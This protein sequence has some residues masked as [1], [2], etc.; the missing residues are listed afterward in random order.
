VVLVAVGLVLPEPEPAFVPQFGWVRDPA[1]VEAVRSSLAAPQFTST[2]AYRAESAGPEDV[3]LWDACRSATGAL[4]PPRNQG[5]IG[6]CVG[7]GTAAALE[8]LACVQVADGES[9]EFR[10]LAPE[11]IYAGSRFEIGGDQIRGDGS[12]GAWAARFVRDYGVLPRD[13]Y[14]GLNL[15]TY[16]SKL[17][18]K[19]G[20]S[21]VPDSLEAI[22]KEHPVRTIANVTS[23]N[24]CRAAIR[25]GYP[26]IVCSDQ[27]FTMTRDDEG[28]CQPQGQWMHCMAIVGV[29]GGERPGAFLLNSW[30]GSAHTGPRGL[31][32]PSPAGFWADADVVDRML[33]QGDSWVFS[34]FVGFPARSPQ[35]MVRR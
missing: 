29:R 30:G 21:G 24:E 2:A 14:P 15:T 31:G 26:L 22:V 11:I 6:A 12:V 32:D 7:F 35:L 1:A 8:H 18:R 3:F 17:C 28:F 20:R 25:H 4:L 34:Q 13:R 33:Q 23:F 9:E 16:D 5:P 10:T 27:G 19:L